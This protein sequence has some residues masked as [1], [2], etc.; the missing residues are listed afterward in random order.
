[1]LIIRMP[2]PLTPRLVRDGLSTVVFT[3]EGAAAPSIEP[4]AITLDG[5][6]AIRLADLEGLYQEE[7]A[8]RMG[9]SRATFAR[10]LAG[11]RRRVADALV[12]GKPLAVSGGVVNHRTAKAWPCPVH[13][14]RK[15]RGRGCHCDDDGRD[16]RHRRGR[17]NAPS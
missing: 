4:V 10:V 17:V 14:G 6:E 11:A 2:R 5:L 3:P 16:H 1:M 8:N 13:G 7:A 15:R 12:N 9:I